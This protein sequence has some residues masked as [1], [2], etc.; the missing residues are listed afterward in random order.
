[1]LFGLISQPDNNLIARI[2]DLAPDGQATA[3][4]TALAIQ[5]G[6]GPGFVDADFFSKFPHGWERR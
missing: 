6:Q 1:M 2:A 4:A 3:G 5:I